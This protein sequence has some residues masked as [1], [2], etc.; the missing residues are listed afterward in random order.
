MPST[1]SCDGA[2]SAQLKADID[3]GR[4]GDKLTGFDPAAA[5]LGTDDEAGGSPPTPHMIAEARLAE[6]SRP[7][8]R[9]DLSGAD[10]PRPSTAPDGRADTR[11]PALAG[12]AL[13]VALGL[14][15]VVI[16]FL[17]HAMS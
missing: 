14:L 2:T 6:L 7:I 5:P 12:V 3:A 1:G 15:V 9:R 17:A 13:G 11:T 4:T 10:R 8:D 16:Y